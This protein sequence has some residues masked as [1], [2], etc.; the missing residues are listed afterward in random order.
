MTEIQGKVEDIVFKNEDNGYVVARIKDKKRKITITGCVPFILEGQN[1]K[2]Q[3]EWVK[4]PHFGQ[5]FKVTSCEE[6]VPNSLEGI[7]KYLS[8]GVISGIGPITAKKNC[9]AFW[10]KDLRNIR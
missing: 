3:G 1:L 6:I 8:S 5:Q 10:R 4:H 9:R 7:E 2:I